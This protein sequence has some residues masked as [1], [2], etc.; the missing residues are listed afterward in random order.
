MRLVLISDT[1]SLHDQVE[2]PPGDVL[3][4]TGD[5]CNHGTRGEIKK[6]DRWL[7][8]L[9]HAHKI[10]IAGNHDRPWQRQNRYARLW[11]HHAHYLQGTARE[12]MGFKLWGSPWQP[13]FPP[14]NPANWAFNLPRGPE[15]KAVWSNIPEDVEILLTHT[16]PAGICD[17]IGQGCHDL[18][19]RLNQLPRLRLHVF[20]H[21][22]SGYGIQ[23][24]GETVFVNASICDDDYNPCRQPIIVD[25]DP[26]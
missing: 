10:I 13:E 12:V 17:P 14:G 24:Q 1:H 25:L 26:R 5:H 23:Y 22:H 9:P 19:N 21:I 7:G 3:I 18:R 2:I 20:G 6:F 4:H 16:P 15:L 11:L 8:G